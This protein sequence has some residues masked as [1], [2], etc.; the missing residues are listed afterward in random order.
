MYKEMWH[1][2]SAKDKHKQEKVLLYSSGDTPQDHN[3]ELKGFLRYPSD[4]TLDCL[5]I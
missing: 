5:V 1:L 3:T 2:L 4:H